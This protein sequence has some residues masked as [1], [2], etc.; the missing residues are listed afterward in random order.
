MDIRLE[1]K[2]LLDG[3]PERR[4]RVLWFGFVMK[5]SMGH[6]L[7]EGGEKLLNLLSFVGSHCAFSS[8]SQR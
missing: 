1:G 2:S 6:P 8:L 7:A 4:E 3:R 5:P